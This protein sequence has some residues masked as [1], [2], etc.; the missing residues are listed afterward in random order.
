MPP[1]ESAAIIGIRLSNKILNFDYK[2]RI[3][4]NKNKDKKEKEIFFHKNKGE[5]FANML[6]FNIVNDNHKI[7]GLRTGEYNFVGKLLAQQM[8]IFDPTLFDG[9]SILQI[10]KTKKPEDKITLD[11]LRRR[12]KLSK[13]LEQLLKEFPIN[14][15]NKEMDKMWDHSEYAGQINKKNWKLRWKSYF[16]LGKW[17]KIYEKLERRKYAWKKN[18]MR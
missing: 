5:K 17:N 8:P 9:K 6:K 3:S 13:Y 15:N 16:Y 4:L 1:Y 2:F 14:N 10:N 11:K 12:A 18:F 7:A